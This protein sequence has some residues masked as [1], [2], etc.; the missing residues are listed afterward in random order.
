MVGLSQALLLAAKNPEWR[1]A[2]IEAY[3]LKV[4]PSETKVQVQH[5]NSFDN[6]STALAAG[7]RAILQTCGVWSEIAAHL[8]PIQRV[9][10]SDRGHFAGLNLDATDYPEEA[11]G[12]V[13]ENPY[14]GWALA[15]KAINHP[16]IH[17][18]A[19]A[20]VAQLQ[21]LRTG[22]Q[23]NLSE[24]EQPLQCR[25]LILADGAES[26]LG[27]Q[28]GIDYQVEDYRQNA[29]IANVETDQ[30][31]N[32]VAYERF[33]AEG[34]V[35]LLPLGLSANSCRSALVWTRPQD[36]TE[37]LLASD[38]AEFCRRLQQMFGTRAG[39][40][41]R[42]GQRQAYPLRL[43]VATEQIRAGLVLMGNAAHFLHPVAGQGFN[44]A[45]RDCAGLAEILAKQSEA[46][47]ALPTLES[48]WR[49]QQGDQ[50]TT[51]GLSNQLVKQFSTASPASALLRGLGILSLDA[52]G[53]ARKAFAQQAM[54]FPV[55]VAR[56]GQSL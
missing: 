8:T 47:G 55:A 12:Y 50:R 18:A 38:E 2:L 22:W 10:V 33:T 34:P 40:F 24:R 4:H 52:L 42:V 20:T 46:V 1:I 56:S 26:R 28:L 37:P 54:G 6:R 36:Q 9:H 31:H 44:L 48:Y 21:R 39:R 17:I 25:L 29:I 51:I 27:K 43:V 5:H 53:P 32:C 3:P 23:L 7:S 49:Y 30:P 11:L 35:A 45:L 41:I 16:S 15:N 19:P 14:L 13:I